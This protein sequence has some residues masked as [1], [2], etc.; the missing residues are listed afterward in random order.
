MAEGWEVQPAAGAR[1]A[2][3]PAPQHRRGSLFVC[4]ACCLWAPVFWILVLVVLLPS[5]CDTTA[6]V[7]CM[8]GIVWAA[9]W[10]RMIFTFLFNIFNCKKPHN[11]NLQKW[12]MCLL[13]FKFFFFT[14]DPLYTDYFY[15]FFRHPLSSKISRFLSTV[16]QVYKSLT[17]Y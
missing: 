10:S 7:Q 4:T 3:A 15:F 16:I 9:L 12:L 6:L 8:L 17:G 2:R 14:F 1:H 11:F 5:P 13:F